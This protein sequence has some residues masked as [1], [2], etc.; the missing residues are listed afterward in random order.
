MVTP[1]IKKE[2]KQHVPFISHCA[3]DGAARRFD[4]LGPAGLT[5]KEIRSRLENILGSDS[6]L[7]PKSAR[8]AVHV[9]A[10]KVAMATAASNEKKLSFVDASLPA[11]KISAEEAARE[12]ACAGEHRG[13]EHVAELSSHQAVKAIECTPISQIVVEQRPKAPFNPQKDYK[14]KTEGEWKPKPR[15]RLRLEK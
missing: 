3:R 5:V 14:R 8:K 1:V 10:L 12:K 15:R 7:P 4:Q 13:V 2:M 9:E 6:P 11:P